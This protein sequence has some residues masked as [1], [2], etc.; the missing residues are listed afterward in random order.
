MKKSIVTMLFLMLGIVVFTGCGSKMDK[1]AEEFKEKIIADNNRRDEK[2]Y[3]NKD[4]SFLIFK[5]K[6]TKRYLAEVLVPYEGESNRTKIHYSYKDSQ[7]LEQEPFSGGES[8]DY[9]K[10][11]GNYEVVYKSGKF[12]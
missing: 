4:F 10:S 5:D 2:N 3:K 6:D 7:K 9:A 8:F 12:K 1:T 11:H